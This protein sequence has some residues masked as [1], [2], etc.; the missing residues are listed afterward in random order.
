M[1]AE[2]WLPRHPAG[3]DQAAARTLRTSHMSP[4]VAQR[5]LVVGV[6]HSQVCRPRRALRR[7]GQKNQLAMHLKIPSPRARSEGYTSHAKQDG[8]REYQPP[9]RT[10][11]RARGLL[12]ARQW[13]RPAHCCMCFLGAGSGAKGT[14]EE[15]SPSQGGQTGTVPQV[16]CSGRRDRNPVLPSLPQDRTPLSLL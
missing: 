16:G 11:T 3:T 5:D 15:L 6:W 1:L 9:P 12:N 2:P 4:R 14:P 10:P 8:S 13:A 7:L